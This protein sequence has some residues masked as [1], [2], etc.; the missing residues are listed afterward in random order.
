MKATTALRKI[1]ALKKKN[2]SYICNCRVV[3]TI[4]Q[5]NKFPQDKVYYLLNVGF[6]FNGKMA[7]N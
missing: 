7:N 2:I 1:S 5:F 6:I 3:A 4:K